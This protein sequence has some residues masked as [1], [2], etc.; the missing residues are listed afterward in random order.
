MQDVAGNEISEL[1]GCLSN[2][3]ESLHEEQEKGA[4]VCKTPLCEKS[5]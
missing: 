3:D 5:I 2:S 4:A 1:L